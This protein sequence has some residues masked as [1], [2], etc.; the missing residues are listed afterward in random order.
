MNRCTRVLFTIA[1]AVST[2]TTTAAV[3][4]GQ[5]TFVASNGN[6]ANPCTLQ[7]PCRS[8]APAIARPTRAAR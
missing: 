4:A 3:A 7:L 8:F 5:R 2:F 6:D 1:I